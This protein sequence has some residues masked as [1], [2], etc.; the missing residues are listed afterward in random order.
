MVSRMSSRV[1]LMSYG[2]GS[3]RNIWLHLPGQDRIPV[4]VI[5]TPPGE[6]AGLHRLRTTTGVASLAQHWAGKCQSKSEETL[7]TEPSDPAA[8]A[9]ID[10][11]P[12]GDQG[13]ARAGLSKTV[14]TPGSVCF[15]RQGHLGLYS[16]FR[17]H[18]PK[19]VSAAMSARMQPPDI[20]MHEYPVI[21]QGQTDWHQ[22]R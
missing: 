4:V 5:V 6:S 12:V 20:G 11:Q 9:G 14:P 19:L 22:H 1:Q 16:P 15:K 10:S 18:S 3:D 21:K 17:S 8:H 2:G 13:E 7:H